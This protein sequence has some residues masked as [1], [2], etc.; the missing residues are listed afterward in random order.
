MG[1]YSGDEMLR[2]E[3]YTIYNGT[4]DEVYHF[5]YIHGPTVQKGERTE[6][7]W[8]DP[9][10]RLY[11]VGKKKRQSPLMLINDGRSDIMDQ[12]D[13]LSQLSTVSR[14]RINCEYVELL[15]NGWPTILVRTTK[16][17]KEGQSLF[18]WY[19]PGYSG[20]MEN[21]E[22]TM[23]ALEKMKKGIQR[24]LYPVKDELGDPTTFDVSLM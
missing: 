6:T 19:G 20:V 11:G 5:N 22:L 1:Q 7:V 21:Q 16:K 13:S 4:A 18:V 14:R 23:D 8:I 15:V 10:D 2:D 12:A 9:V 17:I 24:T 3:F